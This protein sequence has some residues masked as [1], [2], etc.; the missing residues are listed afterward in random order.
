M[1]CCSRTSPRFILIVVI[2]WMIIFRRPSIVFPWILQFHLKRRNFKEYSLATNTLSAPPS[3]LCV[4]SLIFVFF[5]TDPRTTDRPKINQWGTCG[6]W[7]QISI[8]LFLAVVWPLI[9]IIAD[10]ARQTNCPFR[11]HLLGCTEEDVE[12]MGHKCV[13]NGCSLCILY[14][15]AIW[16]GRWGGGWLNIYIYR[17]KWPKN[18]MFFYPIYRMCVQMVS[19]T[20]SN[21]VYQRPCD[22]F[23]SRDGYCYGTV[24]LHFSPPSLRLWSDG[25][26]GRWNFLCNSKRSIIIGFYW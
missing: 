8:Y 4:S 16:Y 10:A 15:W 24:C 13:G 25:F 5:K 22:K 6:L 9:F 20:K 2:T 26:R 18:T 12:S 3:Y 21:C 1:C 19:L 11:M 17:I 7:R 14:N 23:V